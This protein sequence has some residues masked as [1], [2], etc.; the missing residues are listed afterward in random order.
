[1]AKILIV[2]DNDDFREVVRQYLEMQDRELEIH[3]ADSGELGLASA[4]HERPDVVVMDLR[5][6]Q[7][8]GIDAAERIKE[9]DPACDIILLT[10]F[11]TEEFKRGTPK[12]AISVF[13]VKSDIY[14]RLMPAIRRCLKGKRKPVLNPG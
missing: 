13:I 6:P 10:M 2:D 3:E 11:E 4:F 5:L 8:N 12:G 7:M 1:M 9:N 14:D